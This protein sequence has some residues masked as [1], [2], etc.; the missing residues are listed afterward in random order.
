MHESVKYTI[1]YTRSCMYYIVYTINITK[2]DNIHSSYDSI[3]SNLDPSAGFPRPINIQPWKRW[4]PD[5]LLASCSMPAVD[6]VDL[7]EIWTGWHLSHCDPTNPHPHLRGGQWVQWPFEIPRS[8]YNLS[9][10]R[11]RVLLMKHR[12]SC[13]LGTIYI[14]LFQLEKALVGWFGVVLKQLYYKFSSDMYFFP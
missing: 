12:Q 14:E 4:K 6:F 3:A 7:H 10:I 2:L 1:S 9:D 11:R 8:K 13:F 5:L